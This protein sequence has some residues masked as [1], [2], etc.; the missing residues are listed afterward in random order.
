MLK[1]RE[2]ERLWN[3]P[4]RSLRVSFQ[5]HVGHCSM[6]VQGLL[7]SMGVCVFDGLRGGCLQFGRD[8]SES[9][10]DL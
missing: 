8:R 1:P 6:D 9:T 3:G 2:I 7:D 10:E 5:W 4:K